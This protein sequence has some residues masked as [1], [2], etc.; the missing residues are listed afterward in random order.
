MENSRMRYTWRSRAGCV[1]PQSA[2]KLYKLKKSL[3]GLKQSLR[4]WL[5]G[6]RMVVYGMGYKQCSGDHTLFYKHVGH[7]ITILIVY[8]DDIVITGDDEKEILQLKGNL[9]KS[10]RLKIWD[11]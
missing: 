3:Y 4:E 8:I 7:R 2:G 5:D 1:T 11:S 6:F 10:L 9:E